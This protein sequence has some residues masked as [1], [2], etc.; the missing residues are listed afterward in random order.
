MEIAAC[1]E[2]LVRDDGAGGLDARTIRNR[3]VNLKLEW[4]VAALTLD[5]Q[6]YLAH[7]EKERESLRCSANTYRKCVAELSII[8]ASTSAAACKAHVAP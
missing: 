3:L 2:R 8:I 1:N 5:T 7:D 4:E 6:R